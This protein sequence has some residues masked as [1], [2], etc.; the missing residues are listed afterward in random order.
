MI[1]VPEWEDLFLNLASLRSVIFFSGFILGFLL[2]M[3]FEHEKSGL[4][5]VLKLC[6]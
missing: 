1:L 5:V 2:S 3:V 4:T 6:I